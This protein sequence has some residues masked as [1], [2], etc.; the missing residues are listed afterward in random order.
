MT[1]A[2]MREFV[3]ACMDWAAEV[4]NPS[5]RQII[6]SVARTWLRTVQAIEGH[7]RAGRGAALG[8]F[9]TKLN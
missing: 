3:T 1:T 7:P 6:V 8:D 9:R 4:E 2:S 5:D